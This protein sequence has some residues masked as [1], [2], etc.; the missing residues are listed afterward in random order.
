[1]RILK[2][3]LIL[4][5]APLLAEE[6]PASSHMDM[7]LVSDFKNP[8][9]D[10]RSDFPIELSAEHEDNLNESCRAGAQ[11]Q[12]GKDELKVNADFSNLALIADAAPKKEEK[13]EAPPEKK[14]EEIAPTK[15]KE[16][17]EKECIPSEEHQKAS[18]EV[19]KA[20]ESYETAFIKTIVVLVGLLVLVI[21]TVWMFRKISHGRLR[22]MNVL[23]S[24]KILEKRALSPKS[25]LYLIEVGGKQVLIAESQLEV[26]NVA[27]LDW[28]GSDK[29]L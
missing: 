23:K 25:M 11:S 28:L 3:L 29:D 24:V 21:L 5:F 26:R 10:S 7:E 22:G 20:T 19:H 9:S 27:T 16:M 17:D 14:K 12:R 4:S 6:A 13:K 2:L 15:A 1:M 8:L 18:H